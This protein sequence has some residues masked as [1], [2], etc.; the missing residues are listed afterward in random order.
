[1]NIP[2]ATGLIAHSDG[3]VPVH[4][5][6]DALLSA[7]GL[8][9]IGHYFPDTDGE[10]LNADSIGLLKKVV[11]LIGERGFEVAN[12]SIAILAERPRLASHITQMK[13]I[14]AEACG[15]TSDRVG[16]SAGTGEGLGFV[17]KGL[18]IQSTA[19]AVVLRTE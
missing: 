14:I 8:N 1:M 12:V 7:C 17:G 15:I 19:L 10:Y 3:D 18:G 4:A 5:L 6:M 13:A 11:A 16:I 9:D 2:S